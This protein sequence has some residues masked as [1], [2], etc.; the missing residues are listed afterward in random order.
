MFPEDAC[1]CVR[2]LAYMLR[3]SRPA[4]GCKIPPQHALSQRLLWLY[5]MAIHSPCCVAEL[6]EE[7]LSRTSGAYDRFSCHWDPCG[8]SVLV[9]GS[10]PHA[11]DLHSCQC[12]GCG[13]RVCSQ[14]QPQ[15][16]TMGVVHPLLLG[17]G[18]TSSQARGSSR[19]AALALAAAA[20]QQLLAHA[21]FLAT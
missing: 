4:I 10:G 1:F 8:L 18:T 12:S 9:L 16:D 2:C 6:C 14:T 11:A 7:C 19:S 21:T 13:V 3:C 20:C 5:P 15:I 17:L